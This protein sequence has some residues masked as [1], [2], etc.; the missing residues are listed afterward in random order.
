MPPKKEKRPGWID[1]QSCAAKEIILEDLL[2]PDGI[3]FG[4]DN[5]PAEEVWE[6]YKKQPGF[7]NVVFSQF[8]ERLKDHRTQVKGSYIE[9]K[10]EEKAL[11]S[12]REKCPRQYRN[13]MGEL[14]FDLAPAKLLLREDVKE[15]KHVGLV[16]S[17][18]QK[19]RPEYEVF[20]PGNE[21]LRHG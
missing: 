21:R 14:V 15:K 20:K 18:F 11:A 6:F 13:I 12:D 1:W 19:T 17:E 7:E 4:K 16:P 10:K 2:P 9:S 3:L 8:K 5:V